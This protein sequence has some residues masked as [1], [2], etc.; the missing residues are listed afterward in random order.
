MS[1]THCGSTETIKKGW[2]SGRQR[3]LCKECNRYSYDEQVATGYVPN[4]IAKFNANTSKLPTTSKTW[5]ITSAIND[6]ET[7]KDF[8]SSLLLYC[9]H[10]NADLMVV[11][12]QYQ[13]TE[14]STWDDT[15]TEFFLTDNKRLHHNLRILS[16]IRTSVSAVNPLSTVDSMCK[17]DSV[18]M[19]SPQIM[20]KTVAINQVD[21]ASIVYTTGC[22]S[23]PNYT[24]TKAGEQATFNHSFAALVV[25]ID[26]EIDS[27][28]I[29]VLNA[30]DRGGFYDLDKYYSKKGVS[31]NHRIPA[32][33]LGDEHVWHIDPSVKAATFT[34]DNS[35][36]SVLNPEYLIRH[37]VLDFYSASHHHKNSFHTRYKKLVNGKHLVREELLATQLYLIETTPATS[38]SIIVGANHNEHLDKWAD[39]A[40]IKADV[41]N[42]LIYHLLNY[43]KLM[44]IEE[45][46]NKTVFQLWCENELDTDYIK[47]LNDTDSFKL[48]DIEL[49][50]HGHNGTN[51]SRA[52]TSQFSKLGCKSIIGHSHSPSITHGAYCVGHSS[53]SKLDY[54]KGPSSWRQAHCLIHPNGKRQ[55]VFITSG[56]WRR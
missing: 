17:G 3:Y 23:I 14:D 27:F 20:M 43:L 26:E 30:D 56:K 38:T 55:M 52:S 48:H 40:D 9:L 31:S 13:M 39:T 19:P 11:P 6:T 47:F 32:V 22:V 34:N 7:N 28:H 53:Y 33:V 16:G 37:D 46:E 4:H 54:T 10:N 24:T 42:G 25:E 51:G 35:I 12:L 1:C 29:R 44:S 15:L 8:L 2:V 5:V 36:C 18:I 21:P 49:G 50:L 41:A 45:G